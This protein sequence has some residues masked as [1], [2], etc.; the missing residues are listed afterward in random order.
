M[1]QHVWERARMCDR[2][3]AVYIATCDQ[4]I[5]DATEA[6]GAD[7]VMTS[8]QHERASDRVAE[9]AESV[10]ADIY[11]LVQGD[12]PM[13]HPS[14]IDLA[15][16]PLEQ[17]E[18]VVCSNLAAPIHTEEEFLDRNTVKVVMAENGDAL[19][20]SRSPL[21]YP[22]KQTFGQLRAFK[23]VCIIP[24]RADFLRTYTKLSPTPLEVAESID[25]LRALEHGYPVRL[26]ECDRV[27]H[28]VDTP[29]D[30]ERVDRLMREDALLSR[31]APSRRGGIRTASS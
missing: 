19:Y 14:M 13:I 31:Y 24:F 11:V 15:L 16:Q 20:F 21:P 30:L 6:F 9:V 3:D 2:L 27:T 18:S 1:I 28:A 25:M 4:E 17:D 12:E 5:K 29:S 7:A 10:D 23:Q 8:S 26:V 22:F